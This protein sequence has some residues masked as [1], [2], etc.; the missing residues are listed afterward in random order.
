MTAPRQ[1]PRCGHP[2]RQLPDGRWW[3]ST[4]GAV[5]PLREAQP[6]SVHALLQHLADANFPTWLP[7]PMPAQW[8]VAGVARAGEPQV[9]ATVTACVAPDLLGGLADLVVVCEEPGVGLGARYAGAP[10]L[11]VGHEITG[12][13]PTNRIDVAG[14]ATP[15]WWVSGGAERDIFVGEA[16][17]RWLWV[18]AWPATAGALIT[19]MLT[20][21]DLADLAG[22][23][24]LIPLTGLSQRLSG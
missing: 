12:S 8:L 14:H 6:P 23:L 9:Q 20:F 21:A 13:P 15:L 3:C 10:G 18:V 22:H 11:D 16:S 24:E 4:D 1:C 17:G 7:W 19:D 2:V 5:A